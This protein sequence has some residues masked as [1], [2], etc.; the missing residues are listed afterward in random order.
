MA[1][2]PLL[3]SGRVIGK[4]MLY[5]DKPTT[6]SDADLELAGMIATQVA[7]SVQRTRAE[8]HS[9]QSEERLRFALDAATMGTWDWDLIA[10]T[11]Q[12]SENLERIHGL[13]P[14]SFDGA[15]DSLRARA[16]SRRP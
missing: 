8:E 7:F 6:L 5:Y 13:P 14:G 3:N 10:Q 11:V 12:W 2:V 15:F 4:F 16:S 9:R 1:F